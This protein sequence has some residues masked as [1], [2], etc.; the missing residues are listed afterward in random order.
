MPV[1]ELTLFRILDTAPADFLTSKELHEGFDIL[2]Q[3]TGHTV[4]ALLSG[5]NDFFLIESWDEVASHEKFQASQEHVD[6]IAIIEGKFDV[7]WIRHM[8]MDLKNTPF[9]KDQT[10]RGEVTIV[11]TPADVKTVVEEDHA[12]AKVIDE[13]RGYL[14]DWSKDQAHVKT[15]VAKKSGELWNCRVLGEI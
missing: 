9:L 15:F 4:H 7:V 13:E 12:S 1:T 5:T 3:V 6:T 8:E 2:R 10:W 11:E 14:I